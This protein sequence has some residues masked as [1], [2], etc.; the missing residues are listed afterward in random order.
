MKILMLS[1]EAVPFAM[2]GGLGEVV[3]SLARALAA[4]GHDVRLLIPGYGSIDRRLLGA[5]ATVSDLSVAM[6]GGQHPAVIRQAAV[7]GV[8]VGLLESDTFFGRAGL[9]G[10]AAGD[11]P[12]NGRRFGFFCRGALEACRRLNFRPDVIHCHDWQTALTP[13]LLRHELATD[14]FFARTATVFTIHNL[15]F[16]GIFPPTVLDELGLGPEDFTIPR[17]EYY[18]QINL[19][20]GALGSAAKITT[21][22]P[23]YGE[24]ILAAENGCGLEGVLAERRA[25]LKGILNGID[26]HEWNP[27]TD[28]SLSR[29]YT[30]ADLSGKALEK[31]L[32]QKELGLGQL[33]LP[34]MAMV[35]RLTEQKGIDLLLAIIPWLL[36]KKVQL[37]ILGTGE[38][39]YM[40]RLLGFQR[41]SPAQLALV[42][43]FDPGLS[44]RFFAGSDIFLM[45][46][47]FEPCGIGQ[48][49]SLRYGTVP[50]VRRTGGL[51][52]TVLDRRDDPVNYTGFVFDNFTPAAFRGAVEKALAAYGDV[53]G[54]RALMAR[55]MAADFSWQ[56]SAGEYE[57]LYGQALAKRGAA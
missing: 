56:R 32:L 24:E 10:D 26:C 38:E 48:L 6:A 46:S 28:P 20:K 57:S 11:Y 42:T 30:S 5:S 7:N 35:T 31:V 40:E 2:T 19:L 15:A 4:R 16:Q 39:L 47:R 29:G 37:A 12:D 27:A 53:Q 44:R 55:G 22:S 51:A 50:L 23:S 14:P 1:A 41:K 17:L 36:R 13:Y 8:M 52:D 25:D 43:R 54:W 9:Y 3:P 34:L 49:I 21:V 45:P 33:P 18:G